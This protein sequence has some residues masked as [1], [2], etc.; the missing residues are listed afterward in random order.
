VPN[1]PAKDRIFVGLPNEIITKNWA[2]ARERET[3]IRTIAAVKF[4]LA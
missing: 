4:D 2:C 1:R 3:T